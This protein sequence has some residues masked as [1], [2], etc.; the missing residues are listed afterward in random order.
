MELTH[1]Q[2]KIKAALNHSL[3]EVNQK[4]TKT[5]LHRRFSTL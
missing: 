1:G 5:D 3:S 4:P 2:I